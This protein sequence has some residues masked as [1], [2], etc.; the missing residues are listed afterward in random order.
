LIFLWLKFDR[1]IWSASQ[2][3]A[4]ATPSKQTAVALVEQLLRAEKELQH[5]K[6]EDSA[7]VHLSPEEARSTM[8]SKVLWTTVF[9]KTGAWSYSAI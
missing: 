3:L 5:L 8:L 7:T 6:I 2:D 1:I 4:K 9:S